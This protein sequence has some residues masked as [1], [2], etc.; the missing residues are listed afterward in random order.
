MP[1]F[2]ATR[3]RSSTWR[4]PV[5][6]LLPI[7]MACGE[8]KLLS[9]SSETPTTEPT[10][11]QTIYL[12]DAGGRVQSRVTQGSWP[13]WSPDSRRIAF[14]RDGHVRVIG[15]DGSGDI[16][17]AI[18]QFPT[19]S[20]DGKRI[21]FATREGISVMNADG[22]AARTLMSPELFA[23]HPWG[24]GKLSWSPD[25]AL[26]AFERFGDYDG[27]ESSTVFTMTVDGASQHYLANSGGYEEDPSWSP[28][29]S[30]VIYWSSSYGISV[31][32][33]R[34]GEP[35]KLYNDYRVGSGARPT[36][37]PDGRRIAFNT[38]ERVPAI[39]SM[40]VDGSERSVLTFSQ[41]ARVLIPNGFD[42]AWS[43]DGQ[44]IAFV[45]T[46]EK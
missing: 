23:T 40:S 22:S 17:L 43:P 39:I 13:S 35:M 21:A 10:L 27:F 24:I 30:R 3:Y 9:P 2:D 5:A 25:G 11:T 1:A 28:G 14:D 31:V 15:A 46:E 32:E 20:P 33:R 41:D 36:W 38:Q 29:G 45:R 26:I 4:L 42:A 7:L 44:R 37:S 19:W 18:G 16:E 6:V 12:A 8:S 34:G